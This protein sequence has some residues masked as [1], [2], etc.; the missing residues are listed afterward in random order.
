[1]LRAPAIGPLCTRRP[2]GLA[3][4]APGGSWAR[5]CALLAMV[6]SAAP[7]D[8]LVLT[9]AEPRLDRVPSD[10]WIAAGAGPEPAPP[11]RGAAPFTCADLRGERIFRLLLSGRVRRHPELRPLLDLHLLAATDHGRRVLDRWQ[12]LLPDLFAGGLD[13]MMPEALRADL[14][15]L[16]G[17]ARDAEHAV[18]GGFHALDRVVRDPADWE[19]GSRRYL[20]LAASRSPRTL[21]LVEEWLARTAGWQDGPRYRQE[22]LR[23]TAAAALHALAEDPWLRPSDLAAMLLASVAA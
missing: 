21:A 11:R 9:D 8:C 7:E 10:T 5:A 4:W 18:T 19:A 22:A 12:P 20:R 15:A 17:A 3:V 2:D 13:A 16:A 23:V 6:K 14:E 1:V